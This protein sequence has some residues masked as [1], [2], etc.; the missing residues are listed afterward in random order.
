MIGG[1][2]LTSL[3]IGA[4][5]GGMQDAL[6]EFEEKREER[7]I[8]HEARLASNESKYVCDSVYIMTA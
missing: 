5:C 8:K 6:E 4:V 1:L 7:R 2:V 3:Y